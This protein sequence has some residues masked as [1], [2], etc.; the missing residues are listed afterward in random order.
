LQATTPTTQTVALSA[1]SPS[2]IVDF[3][4]VAFVSSWQNQAN[5]FDVNNDGAVSPIDA[6]LVINDLNLKGAR[7]LAASDATPPFIDVNGDGNASPIDA[8][9]VINAIEALTSEGEASGF[10]QPSDAIA[11]AAPVAAEGEFVPAIAPNDD[12]HVMLHSSRPHTATPAENAR[13]PLPF[14]PA[15][16]ISAVA[17]SSRDSRAVELAVID[18]L[19]DAPALNAVIDELADDVAALW[20]LSRIS[21]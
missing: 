14:G 6:L 5:R 20:A 16:S 18:D 19:L 1:N 7:S 17:E 11:A 2:S 21:G 13:I 8:L 12:M 9:Q 4:F 15:D 10:V 3:G